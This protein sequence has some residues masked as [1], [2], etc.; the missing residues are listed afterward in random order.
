MDLNVQC[1]YIIISTQFTRMLFQIIPYDIFD[2]FSVSGIIF[3]N[4]N[5]MPRFTRGVIPCFGDSTFTH[6]T[7]LL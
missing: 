2:C 6:P 3:P 7:I 4:V 1:D 5:N